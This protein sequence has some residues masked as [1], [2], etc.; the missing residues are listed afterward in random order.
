[1]EQNE[2]KVA[3]VDTSHTN[4]HKH[5]EAK[6]HT[7]GA[8]E[9]TVTLNSCQTSDTLNTLTD[10]AGWRLLHVTVASSLTLTLQAVCALTGCVCMSG[11]VETTCLTS[12]FG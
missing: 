1:M 3:N 11:E 4:T 2:M 7:L 8:V 12:D 9:N 10:T 5:D 6:H